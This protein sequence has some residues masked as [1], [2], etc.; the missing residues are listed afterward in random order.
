MTVEPTASELLGVMAGAMRQA[1]LFGGSWVRLRM[2]DGRLLVEN[3][4]RPLD[5]NTGELSYEERADL[6]HALAEI[7]RLR[8]LVDHL[9]TEADAAR[10]LARQRH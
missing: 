1:L 6:P 10:E 2:V 8:G 7:G 9:V 3:V 4:A 5:V